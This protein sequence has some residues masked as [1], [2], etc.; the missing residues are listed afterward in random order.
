MLTT[1]SILE[2][3]M[4]ICFGLS[5]PLNIRK[6]WKAR[7][8]KGMSLPFYLLIWVGYVFA[9]TGKLLSIYYR[10]R[11]AGTA[12]VWTE[13]VPWYVMFFYVVNLLMLSAG[14][15]IY[16]RNA[17]LEKRGAPAREEGENA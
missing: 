12:A 14:V 7:S 5:W 4:V 3:M 10:V 16:F 9:I 1:A 2:M 8:T 6:A 13:V 11:V 17:R 15:L